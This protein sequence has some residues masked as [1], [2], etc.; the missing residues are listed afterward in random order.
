MKTDIKNLIYEKERF[1]NASVLHVNI[2]GLKT[3]FENF[4]NF[5]NNTGSSFNIICLTETWCSNSEIINS[6]YL[7][8]NNHKAIPFERKTNKRGGSILIYV[9]IDL[10]YKIRK[11]LFISDKDKEI[12]TIDIISKESKSTLFS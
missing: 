6:S 10:M 5:L 3:N 12:L 8:I 11:D 7:D 1:E 2:R 4:R 9:K